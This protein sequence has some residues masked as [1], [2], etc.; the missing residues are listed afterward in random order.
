MMH[1]LA[2]EII[3]VNNSWNKSQVI[4]CRKIQ[5]NRV[6]VISDIHLDANMMCKLIPVD[7]P[8]KESTVWFLFFMLMLCKAEHRSHFYTWQTLP[9][10]L[11]RHYSTFMFGIVH[12]FYSETATFPDNQDMNG[13]FQYSNANCGSMHINGGIASDHQYFLHATQCFNYCAFRWRAFMILFKFTV[14]STCN[15]SLRS[16]F[17]PLLLLNRQ[18][19]RWNLTLFFLVGK[20]I[21]TIQ[22]SLTQPW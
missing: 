8:I 13:R 20:S 2:K 19:M 11:A 6:S 3:I 17:S 14:F 12:I 18:K 21:K 1:N 5:M 7:S 22:T 4:N 10:L 15:L 9:T 16:S